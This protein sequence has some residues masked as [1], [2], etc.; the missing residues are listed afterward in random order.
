VT[1]D[2][3]VTDHRAS[4]VTTHCVEFIGLDGDDRFRNRTS[5]R[6][7]AHGGD[8]RDILI[9]GSSASMMF[10]GADN[11]G[12]Y[13]SGQGDTLLGEAGNDNLYGGGGSDKL[14][15]GFGADLLIGWTGNDLLVGGRDGSRDTLDG[16]QGTDTFFSEMYRRG[17]QWFNREFFVDYRPH[18]DILR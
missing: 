16:G 8:G 15:G 5:L 4:R 10:G 9:A 12:L 17:N 1:E 6:T 18:Q 2:G 13:G 7:E 3:R 14:Y 11:D